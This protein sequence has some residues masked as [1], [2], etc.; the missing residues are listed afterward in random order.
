MIDCS[1]KINLTLRITGKRP[2]GYHDLASLFVKIKSGERVLIRENARDVVEMSGLDVD[3]T[4]EN[5]ALKAV[6]I[7]R[8]L[9][10]ADIPALYIKIFKAVQP[11]SGL[12][13]GS[14]NAAAVI[15][16]LMQNYNL[17]KALCL[18]IARRTGADVPFLFEDFDIALVTGIGE[19]I[20]PLNFDLKFNFEA[21]QGRG[22]VDSS[23]DLNFK[24]FSVEIIR[25]D[26]SV[27]TREAYAALDENLIK[28]NLNLNESEALSEIDLIC[29]K[30]LNGE[31]VGL[32]PNDFYEFYLAEKYSG[33]R[34]IFNK[35]EDNGC[36]AWG[37]SGSGSAAFG[38]KVLN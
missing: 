29:G 6:R 8:E 14:G 2:D 28:P 1:M 7:A 37:L 27:N 35:F 33:Y 32:L 13:S 15:K 31:R 21:S 19:V 25:P 3:L 18:E 10:N 22:Q 20:R 17:D 30:L 23:Q 36:I 16:W 24:N 11:G 26:W 9:S 38:L 4:G 12:G 34:D 5:I